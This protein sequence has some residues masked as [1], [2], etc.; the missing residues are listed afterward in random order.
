MLI[1][2]ERSVTMGLMEGK[3]QND[4]AL[5]FVVSRSR[6]WGIKE[7]IAKKYLEFSNPQIPE[8][9]LIEIKVREGECEQVAKKNKPPVITE[10]AVNEMKDKGMTYEAIGKHFGISAPTL[11]NRRQNWELAR[12]RAQHKQELDVGYPSE[13]DSGTYLGGA[14][15]DG[16]LLI[17]WWE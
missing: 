15:G 10:K 11:A 6:I 13:L 16:Y 8:S 9:K 7:E 2:R 14:G 5:E 12:V 17:K 1:E 4:I 3:T